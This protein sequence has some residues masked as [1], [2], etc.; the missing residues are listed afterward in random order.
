M[1]KQVNENSAKIANLEAAQANK[2]KQNEDRIASIEL[3]QERTTQ[4]SRKNQLIIKGAA[5]TY[6]VEN[7]H[8][9]TIE[10]LSSILHIPKERLKKAEFRK[11]GKCVLMTTQD[12]DDKYALFEAVRAIKL[13]NLSINEF[14]TPYKAKLLYELRKIKY[15][16][17]K[18]YSVFSMNGKIF[19]TYQERG[20]KS[21][22]NSLDD[23]Q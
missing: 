16:T 11:S 21:L 23:I 13:V 17:K 18:F 5:L 3:Q 2:L 7:I 12:P 6:E 19:V 14:L 10:K 1:S 20:P 15:E 8:V 22:I 9:E 4:F